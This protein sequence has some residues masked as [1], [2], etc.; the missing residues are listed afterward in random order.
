MSTPCLV[1]VVVTF[2]R[3]DRLKVTL[4]RLFDQGDALSGIVVLDNGSTDGTAAWLA[5]QTDPRLIFKRSQENLGWVRR[6]H[7]GRAHPV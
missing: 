5:T 1:A 2:N 6:R 4:A 3:L 7:E